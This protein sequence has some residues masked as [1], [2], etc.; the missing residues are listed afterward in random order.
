[1]AAGCGRRFP[2]PGISLCLLQPCHC[3]YLPALSFLYKPCFHSGLPSSRSFHGSHC[4]QGQF[5][6]LGMQPWLQPDTGQAEGHTAESEADDHLA[7]SW[8][9]QRRLPTAR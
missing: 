9:E 7:P 5:I 3:R 6:G 4:S 2:L 8:L 1:M